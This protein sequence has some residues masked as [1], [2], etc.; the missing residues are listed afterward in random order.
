MYFVTIS[1]TLGSQGDEIARRLSR[2]IDIPVIDRELSLQVFF[3]EV[4]TPHELQM[5]RDSYSF[6]HQPTAAGPTFRE[7]LARKLHQTL[8]TGPKIFMGMGS[9]VV[10]RDHPS[11]VHVRIDAPLAQRIASVCAAFGIDEPKARELVAESD[12][13]RRKFIRRVYQCDWDDISL[14][15]LMIN[16]GRVPEGAAA[17]LIA[18]LVHEKDEEDGYNQN[19]I[20]LFQKEFPEREFRHGIEREFAGIL[21]SYG[22]RWEYEPTT[23]P[24]GIDEEGNITSAISPDFY[25][26]DEDTY[27]ELTV[28]NPRYMAE[29]RRKVEEFRKQYPDLRIILLNR[30]DLQSFMLRYKLKQQR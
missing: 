30:R 24:L 23:F 12:R 17:D 19:Q 6:Y 16:T 13:R 2:Q 27:V 29:K 20:A 15:T 14:Y 25:L 22:I 7:Y 1:R 28:M 5:L 3:Q 21:D 11:A 10:F 4:A 26:T 18:S 8:A 9:Q